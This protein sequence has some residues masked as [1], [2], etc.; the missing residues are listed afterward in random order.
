MDV[1]TTYAI[2]KG[3]IPERYLNQIDK[4]LTIQ[5]NYI[6]EKER[7]YYELAGDPEDEG[8]EINI[9]TTYGDR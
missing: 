6:S 3:W 5:E 1:N 4:S 9:N 2:K 7:A 8:T